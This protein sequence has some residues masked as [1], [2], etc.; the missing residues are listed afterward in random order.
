MLIDHNIYAVTGLRD[1]QLRAASIKPFENG[2]QALNEALANSG[3]DATVL[4]LQDAGLTVP[5]AKN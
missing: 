2:Q 5:A 3:R 4:V 1:E